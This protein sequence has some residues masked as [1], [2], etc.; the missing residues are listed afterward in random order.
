MTD[1]SELQRGAA[2]HASNAKALDSVEVDVSSL[3]PGTSLVVTWHGRS[4]VVRYRTQK[5]MMDGQAVNLADLKDPIAR[6]ANLPADAP[7]T[8]ANRATQAR[9]PGWSW[10]RSAHIKV[11][12]PSPGKTS[13]AAGSVRA[14]AR[15]T[16]WSAASAKARHPRTWRSRSAGSFPTPKSVS[17]EAGILR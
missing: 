13:S 11:A 15:S 14:M 10:S 16:I 1:P 8:D 12:F 6:N 4:V 9:K 3:T 17:A 2:E 5:E 7:A